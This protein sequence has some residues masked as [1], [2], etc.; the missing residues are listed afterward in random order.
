MCIRDSHITITGKKNNSTDEPSN[1]P[2]V[3]PSPS[4]HVNSRSNGDLE[5]HQYVAYTGYLTKS[6]PLHKVKNRIA[7]WHMRYFV[8]FDTHH[9]MMEDEITNDR[10]VYLSYFKNCS[11]FNNNDDPLGEKT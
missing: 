5:Q 3:T 6:P 11:A 9:G 7:R 2:Q 1:S 10:D 4:L 8:L